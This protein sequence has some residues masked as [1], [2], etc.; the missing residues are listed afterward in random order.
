MPLIKLL[1]LTSQIFCMVK[2]SNFNQVI[3]FLSPRNEHREFIT[4]L[5]CDQGQTLMTNNSLSIHIESG[6]LFYQSFN[7]VKTFYNFT[8]AQH[9]DQTAPVPKRISYH[10]GFEN[11]YRTFYRL[12]QLTM[13]KNLIYLPIKMQN[14]CPIDLMTTS[15]C[16]VEK[17]KPLRRS[18]K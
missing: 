18:L 11:T 4:F 17:D 12:F 7:T 5:L 16:L 14:I 1:S 3:K 6:D 15:K 10:H 2:K 13:S 9:D 8:L